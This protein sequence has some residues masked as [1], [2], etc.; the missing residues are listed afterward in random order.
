MDAVAAAAPIA[1]PERRSG[2]GAGEGCRTTG[3]GGE[4]CSST[5]L[6]TNSNSS[7]SSQ[8]RGAAAE[9]QGAG[10]G[11]GCRTIG[12]GGQRCDDGDAAACS[13]SSSASAGFSSMRSNNSSTSSVGSGRVAACAACSGGAVI[14]RSLGATRRS[15]RR[16][17]AE[18]TE[19]PGGG[20]NT[21]AIADETAGSRR[22]GSGANN[23]E[24]PTLS[25]ELGWLHGSD[26]SAAS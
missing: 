5:N 15:T 7:T 11:S 10:R 4:Q 17:T 6:S 8:A 25:S 3:S 9:V 24:M 12:R 16:P 18:A 23:K 1:R 2:G 13:G 21:N 14:C 19:R 20:A 26:V 22:P